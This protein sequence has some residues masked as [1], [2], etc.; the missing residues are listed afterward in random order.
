MKRILTIAAITVS[1]TSCYKNECHMCRTQA[2][3]NGVAEPNSVEKTYCGL[4][5]KEL[6]AKESSYERYYYD[7]A[8]GRTVFEQVNTVCF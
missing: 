1:F 8:L 7:S 5:K 3:R 4:K 6:K 2:T